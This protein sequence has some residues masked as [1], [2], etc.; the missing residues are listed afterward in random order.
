MSAILVEL[1]HAS[2]NKLSIAPSIIV[3]ILKSVPTT[4]DANVYLLIYIPNNII[5]ILAT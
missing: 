4:S 1:L 5:L 2:I 3:C